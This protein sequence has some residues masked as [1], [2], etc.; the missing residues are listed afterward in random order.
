MWLAVSTAAQVVPRRSCPHRAGFGFTAYQRAGAAPAQLLDLLLELSLLRLQRLQ[1][2][3]YRLAVHLGLLCF[4]VIGLIE[5]AEVL[6]NAIAYRLQL[7]LQ[8]SLAEHRLARG[9]RA[10]LGAVDGHTLAAN[11]S[12]LPGKLNKRR[13]A[14]HQRL[15]LCA[16]ELRN[17]LVIRPQATEQPHHF[18]IALALAL[19]PARRT[20]AAQVPVQV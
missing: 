12:M 10:H 6:L 18:D 11:Q 9:H 19:Q 3:A 8:V 14:T 2:L 13:T 1:T 4:L 5:L 7:P 15:G 20:H 16:P 17:G